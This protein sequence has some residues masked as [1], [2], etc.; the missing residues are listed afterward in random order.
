MKSKS[1]DIERGR[2]VAWVWLALINALLIGVWIIGV[3][4]LN[5]CAQSVPR[6]GDPDEAQRAWRSQE[7]EWLYADDKAARAL[8]NMLNGE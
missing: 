2:I 3:V 6:I 8:R 4:M 7:A 5:G 1:D